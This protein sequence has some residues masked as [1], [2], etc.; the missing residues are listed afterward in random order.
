[1][2]DGD[3]GDVHE[4]QRPY[5]GFCVA[6]RVRRPLKYDDDDEARVAAFAREQLM[7][8]C[9]LEPV[10]SRQ[11]ARPALA[12]DLWAPLGWCSAD[13]LIDPPRIHLGRY[14]VRSSIK[15]MHIDNA[16]CSHWSPVFNLVDVEPYN[17]SALD[18]IMQNALL[19]GRSTSAAFA[20]FIIR[21]F[22][23]VPCQVAYFSGDDARLVAQMSDAARDAVRDGELR[24]T[25]CAFQV[26]DVRGTISQLGRIRKYVDR[27]FRLPT[28]ALAEAPRALLDE[29]CSTKLRALVWRLLKG[30]L[31]WE[32]VTPPRGATPARQPHP[33][34]LK[35][36]I[37]D[38]GQWRV[39]P[40]RSS[41]V[42]QKLAAAAR[43]HAAPMAGLSRTLRN[44]AE[45][46]AVWSYVKKIKAEVYR[47]KLDMRSCVPQY[48]GW[49][50]LGQLRGSGKGI[51]RF[52]LYLWPP[53][54]LPDVPLCS[55]RPTNRAVRSFR[56]LHSLLMERFASTASGGGGVTT[57]ARTSRRCPACCTLPCC[58]RASAGGAHATSSDCATP[59]LPPKKRYRDHAAAHR[60]G[61]RVHDM[62]AMA[63]DGTAAHQPAGGRPIE[64]TGM[65]ENVVRVNGVVRDDIET[66]IARQERLRQ[67]LQMAA[68]PL[69]V[70]SSGGEGICRVIRK[71]EESDE[72]P[73]L[74]MAGDGDA[75][76]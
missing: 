48:N 27:G 28:G 5:D 46:L 42:A 71:Q 11:C 73:V 18:G 55:L 59:S 38:G 50:V 74:R 45:A 13:M 57:E 54:V 9:S 72:T 51:H 32:P 26:D 6:E 56:G 69:H 34:V 41:A 1:M 76:L 15:L 61:R 33:L 67:A 66:A 17:T 58:R 39:V 43:D 12:P 62:Q 25:G 21:E 31:H 10:R 24:L 8:L 52:D 65:W 63:P 53:D 36:A 23:I 44:H 37:T 4:C 35:F 47:T 64:V 30:R 3:L 2:V 40:P 20:D 19:H 68:V 14:R 16:T 75:Q 49:R 70:Q 7:S 29:P 22:D 60:D